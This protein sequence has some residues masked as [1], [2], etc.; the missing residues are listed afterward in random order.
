MAS[1]EARPSPFRL[2]G[3]RS[4]IPLS[5]DVSRATR[6]H[7]PPLNQSRTSSS[8]TDLTRVPHS[9]AR[10]RRRASSIDASDLADDYE[11]SD[12]E[13]QA[14]VDGFQSATRRKSTAPAALMTPQMRSQRLI[15]NSNPRYKWEKYYKSEEELSKMKKPIREYYERNN[16]L[17]Q[18]YLYVDR[19]LDSSLPHSLIQEYQHAEL[20]SAESNGAPH[21]PPTINEEPHKPANPSPLAQSATLSSEHLNDHD[22]MQPKRV[23]RTPKALY[24]VQD[25]ETPLLTTHNGDEEEEQ[26]VMP[27][28]E[29]EEDADSGSRVV[30]IAIYLNLVANTILLILKIIVTVLTSSVSV[31]ASLVDAALDFLSTAIIW[32][33]TRLIS[34]SDHYK[35][36]AGRRR[37]EPIGVLV[38]SVVMMTS[39]VQVAIEGINHLT[40]DDHTIVQLTIPAIAIMS[41]T[42]LIKFF[43]WLYCRLIKNSSVQALAQDAMTDIVFNIFSIIFPLIGFYAKIWWLDPAGGIILSLYVILNWGKT[44]SEHIK[45]LSGAAA[46]ADQ[47]N[48]LLYLCMRFAKTIKQIQGLQA[49]HSGDFLNV[50]A[51]IILDENTSLR[52]SHDLGE[53]LQ[54]VLESVPYV[55][56]AFV[57]MDYASWNLPS[58]MRQED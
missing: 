40:A 36:P 48:V 3:L 22:Q 47:R 27:A 49:F 31:L 34:S 13:A 6:P 5:E 50:E 32:T 14:A 4:F 29:P 24:K 28:Y 11:E 38:F 1:P 20:Y 43:C 12:I 54:Y 41:A 52:D 8:V 46:S 37:L 33:T 15:G 51:D 23:K 42:V 9:P 18:Q 58:H 56:R 26:T 39:F 53:S 35:Y 45:N 7:L 10:T 16:Y 44:S 57:H 2:G 17:I 30:T 25:E 55:D 21:V 19:L